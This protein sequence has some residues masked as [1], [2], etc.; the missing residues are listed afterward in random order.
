MTAFKQLEYLMQVRL[1]YLMRCEHQFYVRCLSHV[2]SQQLFIG[3]PRTT[4][5]YHPLAAL[6]EPRYLRYIFR[7]QSYGV[8]AVESCVTGY[9]NTLYTM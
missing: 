6:R 9:L 7:L 1:V 4:G 3:R 8:H 5:Y 2:S